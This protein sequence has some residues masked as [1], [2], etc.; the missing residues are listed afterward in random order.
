MLKKKLL[1][2][3]KAKIIYE[4]DKPDEVLMVYKDSLTAFNAL[5]KGN[6]EGKGKLNCQI[7]TLIFK[8]LSQNNI[9]H[10]WLETID[11]NQ[12]R[13]QK[14]EI[15]PLE[16][17]V[18]NFMAGSLAKK[19][20]RTEGESLKQPIVE[21]YY[22]EDS[23]NDPFVNDEQIVAL[24]WADQKT[25]DFLKK[26]ALQI[27]QILSDLFQ[28]LGLKLIDFKTEFGRNRQGD[29]ILSDEISPDCMRL[30]DATT[31]KKLDKDRFRQD[32]GEVEESYTEVFQRLQKG[33]QL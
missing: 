2:E 12:M 22:K 20:G 11:S 7:S 14:T 6:F 28:K 5:K 21:F 33:V 31:N 26:Q 27:N 16:V 30:W 3:G 10:H 25:L 19:L 23:L 13:V 15:I 17:V 4:T 1:Y 8:V 9:K 32:L 29:I 18:R 24:G